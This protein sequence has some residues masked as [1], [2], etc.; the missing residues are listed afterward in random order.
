MGDVDDKRRAFGGWNR[1]AELVRACRADRRRRVNVEALGRAEHLE[2]GHQTAGLERGFDL[3]GIVWICDVDDVAEPPQDPAVRVTALAVGEHDRQCVLVCVASGG[4]GQVMALGEHRVPAIDRRLVRRQERQQREIRL[5]MTRVGVG[6]V[7]RRGDRASRIEVQERAAD[8]RI[9][10]RVEVVDLDAVGQQRAQLL[11]RMLLGVG[12]PRQ[13]A[14]IAERGDRRGV[15]GVV[16]V[17]ALLDG[18]GHV[19]VQHH[20]HQ[21]VLAADGEQHLLAVVAEHPRRDLIGAVHHRLIGAA[22]V[23]QRREILVRHRRVVIGER[24][25]VDMLDAQRE[26]QIVEAWLVRNAHRIA[27]MVVAGVVRIRRVQVHDAA[28]RLEATVGTVDR[29][30]GQILLPQRELRWRRRGPT[31]R[32]NDTE[33]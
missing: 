9:D 19:V 11:D 18:A 13:A 20:R 28:R 7:R 21:I 14:G 27:R 5:G 8:L 30:F 12:D 15:D 26:A 33:G 32:H 22:H 1:V 25:E 16:R 29:R 17:V 10:V 4:R 2:H 24:G 23:E 3:S 6:E 31:A